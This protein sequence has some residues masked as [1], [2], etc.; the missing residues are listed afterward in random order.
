MGHHY[1]QIGQSSSNGDTS[2]NNNQNLSPPRINILTKN[3]A[4][5]KFDGIQK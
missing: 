2:T 5:N 3:Q 1:V 4:K